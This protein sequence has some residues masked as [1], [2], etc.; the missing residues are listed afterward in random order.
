MVLKKNNLDELLRP[1]TKTY[2]TAPVIKLAWYRCRT[3]AGIAERRLE[4]GPCKCSQE[5]GDGVPTLIP[6]GKTALLLTS[7]G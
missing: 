3:Q 2:S 7:V 6:W 1:E 4:T 5:V